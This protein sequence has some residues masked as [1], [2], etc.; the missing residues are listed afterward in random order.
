ML[1][2]RS[3]CLP[4]LLILI[5]CAGDHPAG[6]RRAEPGPGPK[7][8][9]DLLN[10][11]LPEI[12]F[13]NNIATRR[14]TSSPTGRRV[15][16]SLEAPTLL[17]RSVRVEAN[18]LA[19]FSLFGPIT[20]RFT[21]PLDLNLFKAHH[22]DNNDPDDDLIYFI[23]VDPASDEFGRVMPL[24][25]GQGNF[26]ILIDEQKNDPDDPFGIF[27]NDPKRFSSNI[28]F[29]TRD[30]DLNRNG[31]LDNGEDLDFDGI[32]DRPNVW[33]PDAESIDQDRDLL[34]F[35][36][37]ETNT[38]VIR[39]IL[40]LRQRTTYA[41]VLTTRLRGQ[42]GNPVRSP[43]TYVNHVNQTLDLAALPDALSRS[44]LSITLDEVAFTWSFTTQDATGEMEAIRAGLYGHGPF[45]WLAKEF[46][47]EYTLD[48]LLSRPS[49]ALGA[50]NLYRMPA[51]ALKQLFQVVAAASPD[52]LS[53]FVE[54]TDTGGFLEEFFAPFND[55]E[56]F[57]AGTYVSPD[58]M[59][60]KDGIAED[61][62]PADDDEVF[63]IDA[64][65]GRATVGQGTGMFFCAV[66][67]ETDSRHPPFPLVLLPHGY[68]AS[69]LASILQMGPMARLGFAS[70]GVDAFSSGM[71]VI[72]GEQANLPFSIE[73]ITTLLE[74][75]GLDALWENLILKGRAR[76]LNNDGFAESA[77]D[78]FTP[79]LFHTRDG[80]RQTMVDYLQLMRIM[81]G[82]DGV[83]RSSQDLNDDG[84]LDLAGDFDGDGRV[85]FGGTLSDGA[86]YYMTGCSLGG[87]T[88]GLM[89]GIEPALS[90]T[91]PM[92]GAAGLAD[93]ALRTVQPR[94]IEAIYM[95][96]FGPMISGNPTEG[97]VELKHLAMNIYLQD[98]LPFLVT[99]Q[100]HPSDRVELHNLTN[101]EWDWVVVGENRRFRL[102]VASDALNGMEKR[103]RLGGMGKGKPPDV[104]PD[105][106]GDETTAFGDPLEIRVCDGPDYSTHPCASP[107]ERF[108]HHE[109]AFTFQGAQYIEGSRLVA[110]HSGYG[111]KRNRP[112]FRRFV[113]IAQ[114][115]VD[116]GDPVVYA[117]HYFERPLDFSYDREIAPEDV[118]VP[119]LIVNTVGDMNVP[120]GTGINMARAAGIIDLTTP[121]PH[122]GGLTENE[123]ILNHGVAEGAERLRLFAGPPWNDNRAILF[124][125]DD[126]DNGTDKFK[127][128]DLRAL[129]QNPLRV[130][131]AI[132]NGVS[133]MRIPYMRGSGQH[134]FG[135]SNPSKDFNI[136]NFIINQAGYFFL[137]DG[138]I[139]SDDPC[140]ANNSCVP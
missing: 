94:A 95:P 49:P 137:S 78:L 124:D 93:V 51:S 115:A 41:V 31:V 36:E 64:T 25:L 109:I 2:Y 130:T 23:N 24:E 139:L 136:D 138:K 15:T 107:R 61:G 101:G 5:E 14:D 106:S 121:L 44:G 27:E 38:L 69:R 70:C 10:K 39:P 6:I 57:I 82:W 105:L 37:R 135:P 68:G 73:D 40:P 74:G 129:G 132:S 33:N 89:S 11:P 67:K 66:P 126:L 58:F 100:I 12:P 90:A 45:A 8:V 22:L 103:H 30:E 77:G 65:T 86:K 108:R 48:P 83:R 16:I 112:D 140:L 134:C 80:L 99:D 9:F 92:A 28:L 119:V 21:E 88:S 91:A 125:L 85:D 76:D 32:L 96:L 110:L 34:T 47:P 98:H 17:E 20:V 52:L 114:I 59:V 50:D 7:V 87:I 102:A 123:V 117:P 43:F 62:Y 71:A 18:K 26:P 116:Q 63:D 13:P 35:Y 19:G 122:Y 42:S 120:I 128:P 104:V 79:N 55:I 113:S 53:L 127:A 56:Y 1:R 72:L 84:E 131:K 3:H 133:A 29:E 81:R 97:G 118:P 54:T 60:D 4:A 75:L 111:Y 46:P